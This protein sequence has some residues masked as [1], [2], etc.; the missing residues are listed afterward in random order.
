MGLMAKVLTS[1]D[2]R[3]PQEP[4]QMSQVPVQRVWECLGMSFTTS[5][6]NLLYVHQLLPVMGASAAHPGDSYLGRPINI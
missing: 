3:P 2:L 4:L 5:R 1:P 6:V